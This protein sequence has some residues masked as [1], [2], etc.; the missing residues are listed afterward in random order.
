MTHRTSSGIPTYI[1]QSDVHSLISMIQAGDTMY[2]VET[3]RTWISG[4]A[5]SDHI[6]HIP[7]KNLEAMKALHAN[8]TDITEEQFF[9]LV[10][11]TRVAVTPLDFGCN[12]V[13]IMTLAGRHTPEEAMR[14][15]VNAAERYSMR[16]AASQGDPFDALLNRHWVLHTGNFTEHFLGQPSASCVNFP[17]AVALQQAER[18]G[19]STPA[20]S[21]T[22]M[23]PQSKAQP[24]PRPSVTALDTEPPSWGDTRCPSLQALGSTHVQLYSMQILS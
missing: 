8:N 21:S 7:T 6:R 18:S 17:S 12:N 3:L 1:S 14:I 5:K 23:R 11:P 4:L 24:S 22:A 15:V 2:T 20:S 16:E 9:H 19:G 13:D 10:A